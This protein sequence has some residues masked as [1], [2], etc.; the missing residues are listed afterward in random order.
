MPHSRKDTA[1]LDMIARMVTAAGKRLADYDPED[2]PRL[3]RIKAIVDEAMVVAIAGMRL[4]GVTWQSIGDSLG[5]TR[6]A[7]IM[8]YGPAVADAH[9]RAIREVQHQ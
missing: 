7:V 9:R 1:N 4:S 5:V 2:L 6:Q 3:L 8:G